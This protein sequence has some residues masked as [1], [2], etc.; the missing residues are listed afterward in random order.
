MDHTKNPNLNLTEALEH[1]I[2]HGLSCEWE[3]AWESLNRAQRARFHKPLFALRNIKDRWGYWTGERNEICLGRRL[4][5]NYSW[6]AVRETLLHEMAHQFAEQVLRAQHEAPHGPSFRA[7]CDILKANPKASGQYPPLD[8][9][10]MDEQSDPEDRIL[11]RIKKLMSLAQS[12]NQ[13]EAE[14][15]MA[16][17]HQLIRKHN[18]ELISQNDQRQFVSIFVGKPALRHFGEEYHLSNLLQTYYFIFGIWVP[19]YVL[20]KGKMGRVLEITGTAQ[21]VRIAAYVYDFIKH[22]IEAQWARYNQEKGLDRFRKTDFSIGIIKGFASK[23]KQQNGMK[24]PEK[25]RH[26]II[27]I[28][29]PLL[30]E[31]TEYRYPRVLSVKGGR[32]NNHMEVLNDGIK[33]G[34]QLIIHKGI[35]KTGSDRR[36]LGFTG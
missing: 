12:Q 6:C 16:K 19:A 33:A 24:Q 23:L 28:G 35:S 4:V 8:E 30:Q 11:V 18:L 5:L 9:V 22:F 36:L 29:D 7:A 10:I 34:R 27:K 17:A 31:Y 25:N 2:L 1:R 26:G 3:N 20:V 14:A 13:H 32:T 21:N 15:A